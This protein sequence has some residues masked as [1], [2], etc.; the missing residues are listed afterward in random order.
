MGI[1]FRKDMLH[2]NMKFS[3]KVI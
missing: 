3:V 1:N 2:V